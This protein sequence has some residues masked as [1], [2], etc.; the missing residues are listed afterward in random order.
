MQSGC[1]CRL[2]NLATVHDVVGTVGALAVTRQGAVPS[3][4]SRG[5]VEDFLCW[6]DGLVEVVG[7]CAV[8]DNGEASNEVISIIEAA[9]GTAMDFSLMDTIHREKEHMTK[10]NQPTHSN[11]PTISLENTFLL[12]VAYL[13][14]FLLARLALPGKTA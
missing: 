8:N 4:P 9:A 11:K 5:E 12:I 1:R 7:E 6:V 13:N 3:I 10:T 14:I 2:E